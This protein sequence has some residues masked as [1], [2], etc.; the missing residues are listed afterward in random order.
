VILLNKYLVIFA[1]FLFHIF[2]YCTFINIFNKILQSF[3]HYFRLS[4]VIT[5]A[6][7]DIKYLNDKLIL[8]LGSMIVLQFQYLML[9]MILDTF[10]KLS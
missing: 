1:Y 10:H 9:V 5:H 3:V 6:Q 7:N 4:I 2:H 8:I